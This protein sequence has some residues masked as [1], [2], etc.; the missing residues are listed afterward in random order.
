MRRLLFIEDD[1]NKINEVVDFIQDT[2]FN[3]EIDIKMSYQT[4]LN[5]IL[6]SSYDVILL[7]MSMHTFDKT[8]NETGGEFMQFAGE[9]I[10]KEMI[11][12]DIVTKTIIV[13][14]YDII[15][16]R[17]LTELK[18]SW[19]DEFGSVYL[20]TVFYRVNETNWKQELSDL[21]TLVAI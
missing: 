19:Q 3:F 17:S 10:L 6:Q 13:T 16:D 5:A 21:L 8:V 18:S 1:E 2:S 11:W 12:N 14:Q 15:G 20:G 4:G 9:E 7:D